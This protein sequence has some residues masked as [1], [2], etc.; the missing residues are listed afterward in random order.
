M[1]VTHNMSQAGRFS[2][3]SMFMFLGELIER[4]DTTKMFDNP[5]DERT[6]AQPDR[7]M[8]IVPFVLLRS[9]TSLFPLSLFLTRLGGKEEGDFLY[10]PGN[11]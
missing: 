10:L 9:K 7:K 1:I 3:C 4:R 8:G 5:V 2:D 11:K 6:R